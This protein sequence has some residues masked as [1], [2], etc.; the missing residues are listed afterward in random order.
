MVGPDS[1]AS[2]LSRQASRPAGYD[3]IAESLARVRD[4]QT[5]LLAAVLYVTN[6]NDRPNKRFTVAGHKYRIQESLGSAT[7]TDRGSKVPAAAA[8]A[9]STAVISITD[10]MLSASDPLMIFSPAR[11][12]AP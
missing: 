4:A 12:S 11:R 6:Q 8:L 9:A 2:A 10:R 1:S 5:R 7:P 3:P